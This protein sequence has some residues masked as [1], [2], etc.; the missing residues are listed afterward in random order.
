MKDVQTFILRNKKFRRMLECF[1]VIFLCIILYC[2]SKLYLYY[3]IILA[4]YICS[5]YYLCSFLYH[6][7][8]IAKQERKEIILEE[9]LHLQGEHLM[10][11]KNNQARLEK[12]K[13]K[14]NEENGILKK[15]VKQISEFLK[16]MELEDIN[17]CENKVIDALLHSKISY[18]KSKNIAIHT[19]VIAPDNLNIS[20]LD[21]ISIFAN[22]FDNAIEASEKSKNPYIMIEC[23]PVINYFVI[24][25]TNSKLKSDKIELECSMSSKKNP[26]NHGLGLQIIKNI[27]KKYEGDIEVNQTEEKVKIEIVLMN[28]TN[29]TKKQNVNQLI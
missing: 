13:M 17:Y 2:K 9:Q 27:V 22:L 28:T 1:V 23:Y 19:Q 21:L 24:K 15:D 18:I 8:E 26:I 12:I 4:S 6:I 5:M 3:G 29:L 11:I 7:L 20:L 14:F 25:V 10:I 16:E